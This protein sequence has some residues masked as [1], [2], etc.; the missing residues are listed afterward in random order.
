MLIALYGNSIRKEH[1]PDV[2]CL[3]AKLSEK[4]I[5]IIM[6]EPLLKFLENMFGRPIQVKSTFKSP[7]EV[8][9]MANFMLSIGG[10]G[11][12]LES[13]T[14]V[15]D[16]GIPV[17][18]INFGRLGFLANISSKDIS[19]AID[20]LS[21][22]NFSVENRTAIQIGMPDNPFQ[23]F[24][25][26]LNDFTIQKKGM[27]MITINAYIDNKFLCTYWADGLIISTPTGS[28]AYTLSVGGPIVS[29]TTN[30]FVVSPIAPHN[31]TVRPL[32]IPD[33]STITL[34]ATTRDK[35]ILMSLDSR[36]VNVSNTISVTIKKANFCIG[37]VN[38][39]QNDYFKTLR[40][41]LMWGADSRN[42][43]QDE[44]N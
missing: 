33:T 4:N 10:D 19:A 25:F 31:L 44:T 23:S 30:A 15:E 7:S 40:N 8:K 34:E 14:F 28:T 3:L 13:A 16:S 37:V 18:G 1:Q 22:N 21:T 39:Q 12:F 24:P 32:V 36:S 6:F 35:E 29:P 26:G 20:Q 17:L 42:R 38:L 27:P 2:E 41:K 9:K 11:T 43:L 5:D